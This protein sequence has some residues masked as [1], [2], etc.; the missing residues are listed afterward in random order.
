MGLLKSPMI[1]LVTSLLITLTISLAYSQG[2]QPIT[3]D[4][5][6]KHIETRVDLAWAWSEYEICNPTTLDYLDGMALEWK[7]DY[8]HLEEVKLLKK[9]DYII[10][11]EI[12]IVKLKETCRS[13]LAN[14]SSDVCWNE[15]YIDGF[16]KEP[17]SKSRWVDWDGT[18]G[19]TLSGE[20]NCERIRVYGKL[21]P[22]LGRRQIDHIPTV[23]GY[24]YPEYSWWDSNWGHRKTLDIN[25]SAPKS[26]LTI[27]LNVTEA[28]AKDDFSDIR[29]IGSD[30]S[31]KL[32]ACNWTQNDG[33]NVVIWLNLSESTDT[34]IFMYYNNSD[35][36]ADW[37]CNRTF[38]FY[39]DF[40][41]YALYS[42]LHGQGGWSAGNG[43]G[44]NNITDDNPYEGAQTVHQKDI[45]E[46]T[47]FEMD[48]SLPSDLEVPVMGV[49]ALGHLG[50]STYNRFTIN[51][52]GG[53]QYTAVAFRP[54][55]AVAHL[56][57]GGWNALGTFTD[58]VWMDFNITAI[59]ASAYLACSNGLCEQSTPSNTGTPSTLG[60]WNLHDGEDDYS[61][62][63][64]VYV[65]NS[66]W[67]PPTWSFGDEET[68]AVPSF[69]GYAE[70]PASPNEDQNVQ[71]QVTINNPGSNTHTVLLELNNG[72]AKNWTVT[73]F[74]GSG[75]FTVL[76][77][78]YTAH[79]S[80]T[81]RWF[82]NNTYGMANWSEQQS[83]DIAN[84]V[85]TIPS[86]NSP[87][88]DSGVALGYPVP[89]FNWSSTDN[90][91]EDTI[92][93]TFE[94]YN[95]SDYILYNTTTTTNDY[96]TLTLPTDSDR[97]YHWRVRANDTYNASAWSSNFTFQYANWT[98]TFEMISSETGINLTEDTEIHCYDHLNNEYWDTTDQPGDDVESPWTASKEFASMEN[99]SCS[100][101]V[102]GGSYYPKTKNFM[103]S[104]DSIIQ[105][106]FSKQA[107]LTVEEHTWLEWLYNCWNSG[108]CKDLL[109]SINLTTTEISETVE[110][111]WDQYKRTNQS[112]VT[113][114][115]I[116]NKTVDATSNLTINYSIDV[117]IKEGYAFGET[118][119]EIRLDYLPIRISYW[120][121]DSS[122][123]E[124]CYSQGNYSVATAEPYCQPLT[125]YTIGQVSSTLDFIVDLRPSLPTGT[126]TIV[127]NIEIDPEQVWI[128]Y[129]Q[130]AIGVVE[131]SEA[132]SMAAISLKNTGIF[133]DNLPTNVEAVVVTSSA[134]ATAVTG[135]AIGNAVSLSS[136]ISIV[137]SVVAVGLF[138][139]LYISTKYKRY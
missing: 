72:S 7:G 12:P 138:G 115:D 137:L 103:V 94:I 51:E 26:N 18:V 27:E 28:N 111:I 38:H 132:N 120:F 1:I 97:T 93:Y 136:I 131:V 134:A 48:H 25:T 9:E 86:L 102:T 50:S 74:S 100:F 43:A 31:T 108:T 32:Y 104:D 101:V 117:P 40:E 58:D 61:R 116:I 73:P 125:V 96:V 67:P 80:L 92:T 47:D 2:Q 66:T 36:V 128:N 84:Q 46:N 110:N 4:E 139:F 30:G 29:F 106:I 91:A 114:E 83:F 85:P 65:A 52:S 79:D 89:E 22:M 55:N 124:T 123:N 20:T 57:S 5:F 54:S 15:S 75:S 16:F 3:K 21:S 127:R 88:D 53:K 69:S 35:A 121:L 6:L 8:Q 109:D 49:K 56:D 17:V 41:G 112:V 98:I 37:D 71:L 99:Y 34:T 64:A 14:E 95:S 90:D 68:A 78:N 129:G 105:T 76:S 107:Y 118:S 63:D 62:W 33:V 87:A 119:G 11:K 45:V 130:E 82:A 70:N 24:T 126:Y 42:D 135:S 59:S 81:Y 10:F 122:D 133:P 19:P 113:K 23:F 13:K 44:G 39:D 60:L 77:G